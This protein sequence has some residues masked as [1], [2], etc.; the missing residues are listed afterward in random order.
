MRGKEHRTRQAVWKDRITPAYAGKS[1]ALAATDKATKDHPRVCGE[2][3]VHLMIA[4]NSRGSPPRMRGKVPVAESRL[5]L[6]R[7][8]PAYAGKRLLLLLCSKSHQDHPRVCGEKMTT[9]SLRFVWMGSPPRMRGKDF[10]AHLQQAC[11][12]ITP[13]Y[14]GK[15]HPHQARKGHQGDHPRVCGE[16]GGHRRQAW[17]SLGSPPRMR[18]KD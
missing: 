11:A 18:G 15:S 5:R 2:K 9:A 10:S 1:A 12:G 17:N 16:K 6:R 13:A 14:A 7:I 4:V 8:T 3:H